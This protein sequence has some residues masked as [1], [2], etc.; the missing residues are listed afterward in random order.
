MGRAS[1]QLSTASHMTLMETGG[2]GAGDCVYAHAL[3]LSRFRILREEEQK[4]SCSPSQEQSHSHLD[5]DGDLDV[6]R[7]PA[8]TVQD[9]KTAHPVILSQTAGANSDDDEEEA[10][11]HLVDIIKIEH[12]M[13]TPLED[14][15]KQIWRG[16]LLLSDFILSNT[17]VFRGATV[18]E[19]GAGTGLTSIVAAGVAKTV[20]CTGT[21]SS[22]L[23]SDEFWLV[24]R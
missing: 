16:A 18:L 22:R 21:G 7:K 5:K 17:A 8:E 6:A 13:A 20:Y 9:R 15:G 24:R 14:V 4:D 23:V 19:L 10:D 12:T 3:F 11:D 2:G 1:L